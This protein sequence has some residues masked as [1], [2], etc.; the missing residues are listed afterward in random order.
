MSSGN[1]VQLAAGSTIGAFLPGFSTP[2]TC[3]GGTG[4]TGNG[5]DPSRG[6][7]ATIVHA[8]VRLAPQRPAV[9]VLHGA[10][11]RLQ[12]PRPHPDRRRR[13]DL[14]RPLQRPG[15]TPG[16]TN[17]NPNPP[18]SGAGSQTRRSRSSPRRRR[19]TIHNAAHA[20]VTSV[21]VGSTVHDLVTVDGG[22]GNPPPTGNVSVDWFLNGTAPA[23]PRSTRAPS[24]RSPPAAEQSAFDATAFAFTVNTAGHARLPRALPRRP[25]QPG[26]RAVRRSVRAAAPWS[27]RTSRS[28]RTA[29]TASAQTHTFTGHVNVN[30]G[31]GFVNAPDGTHDQLH[32]QRRPGPST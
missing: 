27:T 12:P 4:I 18:T 8:P 10:G 20:V 28:R 11:R 21:P 7:G 9:L 30:D 31:T 14:A 25:G 2:P 15:S 23:R 1:V 16:N 17:C 13:A 29:S 32:H 19:P 6:P 26:L 22:A 3:T 5:S 24:G